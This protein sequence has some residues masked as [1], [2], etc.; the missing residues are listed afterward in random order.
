MA[1]A[2]THTKCWP[3][4]HAQGGVNTTVFT[5]YY[6]RELN[7][8]PVVTDTGHKHYSDMKLYRRHR[9]HVAHIQLAPQQMLPQF[10]YF[11]PVTSN[12]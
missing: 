7:A 1:V 12:Q 2:C 11:S 6:S 10:A 3:P 8:V 5:Q 9:A 4:Q